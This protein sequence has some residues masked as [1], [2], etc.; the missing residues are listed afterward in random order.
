ML[1]IFVLQSRFRVQ[2]P[3]LTNVFLG[4]VVTRFRINMHILRNFSNLAGM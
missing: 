2:S 4:G 1:S 3:P